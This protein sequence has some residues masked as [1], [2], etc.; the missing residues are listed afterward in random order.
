M[1]PGSPQTKPL[2]LFFLL[3]LWFRVAAASS[4][5]TPLVASVE[6][7]EVETGHSRYHP[8]LDLVDHDPSAQEEPDAVNNNRHLQTWGAAQLQHLQQ[9]CRATPTWKTT[10]TMT[11]SHSPRSVVGSNDTTTSRQPPLVE[12]DP[13]TCRHVWGAQAWMPLT[14]DDEWVP[15]KNQDDEDNPDPSQPHEEQ[16]ETVP[17]GSLEWWKRHDMDT[18]MTQCLQRRQQDPDSMIPHHCN[19]NNTNGHESLPQAVSI[20]SHATEGTSFGSILYYTSSINQ[21]GAAA[22]SLVCLSFFSLSLS[23]T[24]C[25]LGIVS[26]FGS[27]VC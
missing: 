10:T 6:Q 5:S 19:N 21:R 4:S 15:N 12:L 16:E 20:Y 22:F 3:A 7:Q 9:A 24:V 18:K 25:S 1:T 26:F 14:Q 11:S 27:C 8:G 23:P 17:F 13:V 2:L